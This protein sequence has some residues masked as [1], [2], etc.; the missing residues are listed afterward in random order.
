MSLIV[1]TFPYSLKNYDNRESRMDIAPDP[2]S[3][4]VPEG[5]S[6]RSESCTAIWPVML[7]IAAVE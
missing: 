3:G 4:V 1:W 6:V 5:K 2:K 7:S